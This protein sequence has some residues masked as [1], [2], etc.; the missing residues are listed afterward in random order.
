MPK[1]TPAKTTQEV[2]PPMA[3]LGLSVTEAA[4]ALG[5]CRASIYLLWKRGDGPRS[6]RV[7][8]RRLISPEALREYARKLQE[9]GEQ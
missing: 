7:G 4:A 8:A 5:I 9:E 3:R 2:L 6:F 1:L